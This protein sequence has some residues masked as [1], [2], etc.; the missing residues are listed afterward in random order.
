[1]LNV[2]E[3]L[4]KLQSCTCN[5]IQVEI[6]QKKTF[7]NIEHMQKI[8]KFPGK[9][10]CSN[11]NRIVTNNNNSATVLAHFHVNSYIESFCCW[12]KHISVTK[13]NNYYSLSLSINI[14]KSNILDSVWIHK[15]NMLNY[16]LVY[17]E[18]LL[19]LPRYRFVFSL[20]LLRKRLS[21][22]LPVVCWGINSI[23]VLYINCIYS[24]I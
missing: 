2:E 23:T 21:Y 5:D 16:W 20:H 24:S 11:R 8:G 17:I 3:I 10:S 6:T 14:N 19:P 13:D 4:V 22:I 18:V 15:K 7:R 12:N 1:L 9:V